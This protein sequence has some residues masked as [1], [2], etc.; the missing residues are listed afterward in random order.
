MR[1]E[2]PVIEAAAIAQTGTI[3][4]EAQGRDEDEVETDCGGEQLRSG[5]EPIIMGRFA[6]APLA[7]RNQAAHRASDLAEHERLAHLGDDRKID[8]A[9]G[10][11]K[12][13]E[14]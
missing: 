11:E 6:N 13:V 12:S 1:T 2:G 14:G 3:G 4:A 5:E 7:L 8:G 10:C 9:P